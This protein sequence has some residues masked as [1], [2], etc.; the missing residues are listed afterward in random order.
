MNVQVY[1]LGEP[2]LIIDNQEIMPGKNKLEALLF[3]LLYH[4]DIDRTEAASFFWPQKSDPRAKASLRNSLYEIRQILG[5]D[6]FEASTRDRI[7]L[8]SAISLEKD[9]D[10]LLDGNQSL[11]LLNVSSHIF[12]QNKELKDNEGYET[13]LSSM[14]EAYQS[15]ISNFLAAQLK[16]AK[17]KGSW[18]EVSVL[19]QRLLSLDPYNEVA[20]RSLLQFYADSYRYNEALTWY[21]R[22]RKSLEQDLGVEP[23]AATIKLADFILARKNQVEEKPRE[24]FE[25]S[26]LLMEMEEAYLKFLDQT[27]PHHVLVYGDPGSGRSELIE[28]FVETKAVPIVRFTL[29]PSNQAI[30]QGFLLKWARQFS[31]T[32]PTDFKELLANLPK[33]PM[34]V[35][36]YNVEN[37]D[38]ESLPYLEDF[39]AANQTQLFFILEASPE[40]IRRG[41]PFART[42][43]TPGLTKI[44]VPLLSRSEMT[45]YSKAYSLSSGRVFTEAQIDRAW[46]YSKGNLILVNE[47]IK[48][49]GAKEALFTKLVAGLT[50]EQEKIL[51]AACV[52]PDGFTPQMAKGH[53]DQVQQLMENL[54]ELVLRGL[55]I[56]TDSRLKIKYPPLRD[57]LYG[58]LPRFYRANLHELAA[59]NSQDLNLS[60]RLDARYRA[61]HWMRANNL[62]KSLFYRLKEVELTL[63]FYDE[64]FP[65]FV[66]LADLPDNFI[67]SRQHYY[68]LLADIA[69]EVDAFNE[70]SPSEQAAQMEMIVHYLYGRLMIAGG[71]RDEGIQ[72]IRQVIRQASDLGNLEYLLKGRIEGIHYAIQKDDPKDMGEFI[73]LTQ[74]L[75]DRSNFGIDQ[76]KTA[77]VLRLEGLYHYNLGCFDEALQELSQADEILQESR[78]R[79]NGFLARAGT[80]NYIGR[81]KE[82]M[83][84]RSGA[85]EA[86][87]A[88]IQLVEGKVHKCL[89]ILYADYGKFLWLNGRSDEAKV[90]LAKALEE[91][92]LL[93]TH[94]KRPA[95][96]AI[97]GLLA[98]ESGNGKQARSHLV[99]AQIYYKADQRS[100]EK[101]LIDGLAR[102]LNLQES[103]LGIKFGSK[104]LKSSSQDHRGD[105]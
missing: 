17:D 67:Q 21:H 94:W 38:E 1:F 86:Y 6:L 68:D 88:S 102:Q 84:D 96:E 16:L 4:E 73:A 52:Y 14:R 87:V 44:Q 59:E 37:M 103:K 8:S 9:V 66:E 30:P 99:N 54:K 26:N 60:K 81:T 90:I 47:Y 24:A 58:N 15:I 101:E 76:R 31:Q 83:G 71:R 97:C 78:Y 51:D 79:K 92:H 104:S 5:V 42:A 91:Y 22:F 29:E 63:N 13:W 25:R 34:V 20:L 56:E 75:M 53:T 41:H 50:P 40:F 23:E 46:E 57:W 70:T 10:K 2:R 61:G 65:S 27:G 55:L 11:E 45:D 62:G 85:D 7:V 105:R 3:Y 36:L 12:L 100:N 28:S 39:L 82:A 98:L 95:V 72:E 43:T 80:L 93:G 35:V 18:T 33:E 32:G 48:P 89:D 49:R 19:A 77:E 69:K 64:L 74:E